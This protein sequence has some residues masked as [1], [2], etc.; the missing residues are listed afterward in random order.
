LSHL[1][2]VGVDIGLELDQST[3]AHEE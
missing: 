3:R 1:K 2:T